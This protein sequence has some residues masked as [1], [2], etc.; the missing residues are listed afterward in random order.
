MLLDIRADHLKMVQDILHKYVPERTVWVFGSRAKWLAKEYSDLDLCI[1]G[2]TQLKFS[3]I[4]LL[5]EAFE[6]SNLPYKVD[7]VDWATTSESFRKIIERDKVRLPWVMM[8]DWEL[9]DLGELVDFTPKRSIKKGENAPFV[10]MADIPENSKYISQY[11]LREF[12]GG[13]SRFKNGDTVFARITPCLE[14]GKTAKISGL[15]DGSTAHGSTEFIVFSARNPEIDSEFLY[16][17]ARHQEFRKYAEAHME[18]TSG[19]QRVAWQSL[20]KYN[21]NFPPEWERKKI[22]LLL[23]ALDD[24]IE[25]NRK[26]NQ[27]L[28][29]MAQALFKSWF[30][31][32]DPVIDNALIAGNPIPDELTDRANLRRQALTNGTANREMAK[33]F[34][35]AFQNTVEMGW[36]PAG[37]EITQFGKH[38]NF[39]TGP[40]FKSSDFSNLG[41][42]LARG[43]NVKEGRFQWGEK[44]RYWSAVDEPLKKYLLNRGDVLLGMDGSKVGKNRVRVRAS[45][46]PCLL[47]QRVAKLSEKKT[48]CNNF[49]FLVVNSQSFRDYVDVIKTGSAIPHISGGQIKN[50]SLVLPSDEKNPIFGAFKKLATSMFERTDSLVGESNVLTKSRDTLLPKL[51]SGELRISDTEKKIEEKM[52]G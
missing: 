47:V 32:F 49:I 29:A 20:A 42:R 19:R 15:P 41:I 38:I 52:N 43:D 24:K 5:A 18:G 40:A 51:I 37:W 2:N 8:N 50:F 3:T 25:L 35:D 21:T 12:K 16:Y 39:Q 34:P 14:N 1:V 22:G 7:V 13:G 6:D 36:I 28:E 17:L 23:K 30:V 10:C 9:K 26:M 44:T 33:L 45:D 46:L 27:T 48:V 4:G 31:D 11:T